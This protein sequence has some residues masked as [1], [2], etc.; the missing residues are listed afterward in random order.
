MTSIIPQSSGIYII[1]NIKNGKVYIG[2]GVNIHARWSKHKRLLKANKHYNIHL[3]RSWNKYGAS[4]FKFFVLEYCTEEQLNEREK[5]YISIYKSK[6]LVY[7]LTDGGEGM[8]GNIPTLETRMKL[9]VK[10]KGR[11]RGP[12]SDEHR[13]KIGEANKGK[14][15]SA[16]HCRQQSERQKGQ[17]RG[18]FSEEHKLK[19]GLSQKGKPRSQKSMK[20]VLASHIQKWI[21]TKPSGEILEIENLKE[22]CRQNNLDQ[23][24]MS[25]VAHGKEKHHKQWKC[26]HA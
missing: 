24:H 4:K 3:Q 10:N 19:I 18:P 14:I 26:R 20:A 22:F 6:G 15:R 11:K 23:R 17:K 1:K 8:L 7:N 16:E 13:R 5:H 21:V 9:S 25:N 12:L 2:K